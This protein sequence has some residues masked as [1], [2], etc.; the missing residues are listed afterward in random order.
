MSWQNIDLFLN[1]N[2]I[3]QMVARLW[4]ISKWRTRRQRHDK[5]A[6]IKFTIAAY[7]YLVLAIRCRSNHQKSAQQ[8]SKQAFSSF[9]IFVIFAAILRIRFPISTKFDSFCW[10]AESSSSCF[11]LTFSIWLERKLFRVWRKSQIIFSWCK[12]AACIKSIIR[13]M[14][15]ISTSPMFYSSST[16]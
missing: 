5:I 14:E 6:W 1:S 8:A 4:G 10:S 16:E 11:F 12:Q 9:R 7:I 13:L 15:Y 2:L 3:L